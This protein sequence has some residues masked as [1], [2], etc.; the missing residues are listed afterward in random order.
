[1]NGDVCRARIAQRVHNEMATTLLPVSTRLEGVGGSVANDRSVWTLLACKLLCMVKSSVQHFLETG[2]LAGIF[3][4]DPLSLFHNSIM[5]SDFSV[6]DAQ[7]ILPYDFRDPE[8][9]R[10]ALTAGDT[11]SDN[12]EGNRGLAQVGDTLMNVVI[13]TEGFQSGFSRSACLTVCTMR[14]STK[15]T[16]NCRS[17]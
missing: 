8:L 2:A 3:T 17:A 7:R 10:K 9:L 5:A 4:L 14:G 15:L 1:M 16:D 13:K 12:R 6:L 11:N